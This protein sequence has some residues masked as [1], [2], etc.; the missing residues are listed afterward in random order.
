MYSLHVETLHW[1][2]HTPDVGGSV[3]PPL[4]G[5][6]A[7]ALPDGRHMLLFGGTGG[8]SGAPT[9]AVIAV[10]NT[11]EWRYMTPT[12]LVRPELGTKEIQDYATPV[13]E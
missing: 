3:P 1:K 11:Q 7:A 13:L 6:Q 10:L 8:N 5:A 9:G 4:Y 12:V 2:E